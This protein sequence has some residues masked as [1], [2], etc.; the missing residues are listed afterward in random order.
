MTHEKIKEYLEAVRLSQSKFT[1]QIDTKHRCPCCGE[2]MDGV[3]SVSYRDE[4]I[5]ICTTCRS[6]ESLAHF[7]RTWDDSP[8][9]FNDWWI[10]QLFDKYGPFP[11]DFHFQVM[12]PEVNDNKTITF[13]CECWFDWAKFGLDP[14]A[15]KDDDT[16][17]NVYVTVDPATKEVFMEYT[18]DDNDK[19]DS[20]IFVLNKEDR[21]AVL[22]AIDTYCTQHGETLQGIVDSIPLAEQEFEI[23]VKEVNYGV[24]RIRATSLE[25][26]LEK[27]HDAYANGE[28]K[29][30]KTDFDFIVPAGGANGA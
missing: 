16:W 26:A 3:F 10:I 23:P 7:N 13:L 25:A 27:V 5:Y 28:V 30:G 15:Y 12:D 1:S 4:G 11:S 19:N 22:A 21:E 6:K 17:L 14:A 9:A 2:A 24:A 18:I 20:F 29:W 8:E